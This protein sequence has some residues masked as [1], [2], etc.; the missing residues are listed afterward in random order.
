[1][2]QSVDGQNPRQVSVGSWK[3]KLYLDWCRILLTHSLTTVCL[4]NMYPHMVH[5]D[6]IFFFFSFVRVHYHFYYLP[7]DLHTHTYIH[8]YIYIQM[9]MYIYIYMFFC[10]WWGEGKDIEGKPH[11]CPYL[12]APFCEGTP[13]GAWFQMCLF[14][15][16]FVRVPCVVRRGESLWFF[17][18]GSQVGADQF[19]LDPSKQPPRV[20][21]R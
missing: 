17:L 5:M 16:L 9:Y 18:T 21:R 2:Y 15:S 20:R 6:V 4:L 7:V 12:W 11:G 8:I 1:M 14:S 10:F 3:V 13:F 19:G